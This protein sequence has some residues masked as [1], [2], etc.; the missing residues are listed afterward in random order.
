MVG[1]FFV[2]RGHTKERL[3]EVMRRRLSSPFGT[4]IRFKALWAIRSNNTSGGLGSSCKMELKACRS[5]TMINSG[6]V[7]CFS[8]W[9]SMNS[10]SSDVSNRMAT[11]VPHLK[12]RIFS[13]PIDYDA[14]RCLAMAWRK[15]QGDNVSEQERVTGRSSRV[16]IIHRKK[17]VQSIRA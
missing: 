15:F 9:I 2:Y 13:H 7:P 8:T 14:E 11:T 16:N 17:V 6:W 5:R 3:Y 12:T 4:G 10:V 1:S